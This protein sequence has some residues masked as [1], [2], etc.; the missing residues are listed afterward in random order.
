M[1]IV[2]HKGVGYVG[3]ARMHVAEVAVVGALAAKASIELCKSVCRATACAMRWRPAERDI[4]VMLFCALPRFFLL[5]YAPRGH[6]E[7]KQ[8]HDLLW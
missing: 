5:G 3:F 7:K 8:Y 4:S 6:L 2:L 1:L